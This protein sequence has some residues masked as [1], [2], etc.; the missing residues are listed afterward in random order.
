MTT[1]HICYCYDIVS[2][3][4]FL[5]LNICYIILRTCNSAT[6]RPT[7]CIRSLTT[8]ECSFNHTIGGV[9]AEGLGRGD[10]AIQY[11]WNG[12]CDGS[13]WLITT[14]V[15]NSN[16]HIRWS[17]DFLIC[18]YT[19]SNYQILCRCCI[20]WRFLSY[21]RCQVWNCEDTIWNCGFNWS[22]YIIANDWIHLIAYHDLSR[23]LFGFVA[24]GVARIELN[25]YA[26]ACAALWQLVCRVVVRQRHIVAVVRRTRCCQPCVYRCIV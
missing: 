3:F 21:N 1:I 14:Q 23:L 20:I 2:I 7:Q 12:N 15:F 17:W 19:L 25:C 8:F 26:V 22:N 11:F 4:Q 5:N 24:A 10:F 13:E 18:I 16:F 6:I 9:V